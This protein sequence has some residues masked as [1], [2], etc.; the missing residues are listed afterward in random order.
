MRVLGG[1]VLVGLCLVILCAGLLAGG[2]AVLG[3]GRV[4]GAEVD[5]GDLL[6]A[7]LY[8]GRELGLDQSLD[9][10]QGLL[11]VD[12]EGQWLDAVIN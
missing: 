6:L 9:V 2:G 7:V 4:F 5:V 3:R 12:E 8:Y 10:G 1:V 11:G